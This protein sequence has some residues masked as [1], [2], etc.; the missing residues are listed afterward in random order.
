MLQTRLAWH[1]TIHKFSSDG[2]PRTL[3]VK[4]TLIH[5]SSL[6]CYFEKLYFSI[7]LK[8]I[9][10][11]VPQTVSVSVSYAFSKRCNWKKCT[12]KMMQFKMMQFQKLCN[13]KNCAISK[14]PII[15]YGL[16]NGC[17]QKWIWKKMHFE[18]VLSDQS[19]IFETFSF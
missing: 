11:R 10:T 17:S 7:R 19:Q 18:M 9:I 16:L 1:V 12:F 2:P 13:I 14:I 5:H 4:R 3:V 8:Q 15:K 6:N